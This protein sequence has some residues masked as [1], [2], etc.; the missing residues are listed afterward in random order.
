MKLGLHIILIIIIVFCSF[1]ILFFTHEVVYYIKFHPTLGARTG[2]QRPCQGVREIC[3]PI[4][5]MIH[6]VISKFR[7]QSASEWVLAFI[8]DNKSLTIKKWFQVV[9]INPWNWQ[10]SNK[11]CDSARTFLIWTF[12]FHQAIGKLFVVLSIEKRVRTSSVHFWQFV[13]NLF[14]VAHCRF[15]TFSDRGNK[16]NIDKSSCRDRQTDRHLFTPERGREG[17]RGTLNS[18][19]S[20]RSSNNCLRVPV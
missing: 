20:A 5:I 10:K 16:R 18:H 3:L 14:K 12:F 4:F 9:N 17:E 13:N 6:S 19:I 8:M 11:Y 15:T 7:D 1:Q 2:S